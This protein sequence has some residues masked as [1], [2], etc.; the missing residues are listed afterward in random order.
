[1][2]EGKPLRFSVDSLTI[3]D[4]ED[5]EEMTGVA[6]DEIMGLL[7]SGKV[8]ENGKLGIPLKILKALVF[9]VYRSSDPG[10]TVED[11]RK[12]RV[13]EL[14]VVLSEP[15]PTGPNG[16]VPSSSSATSGN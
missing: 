16:V 9:I 1:M 2:A 3:G 11:A 5:I 15:D 13:S 14:E 12:V 6:F 10:F 4:L 8:G 7:I